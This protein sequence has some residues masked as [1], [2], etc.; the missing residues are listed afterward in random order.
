M[1]DA[2]VSILTALAGGA[3]AVGGWEAVRYM[4]NRK[5]NARKEEAEA[6]SAEFGVLRDTV[7]FLQQQLKEKEERFAEQTS[8]VR[9]QNEDIISLTKEKAAVELDLQR[10]RCIVKKCAHREPQN[11]Y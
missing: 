11:G 6:D 4:M 2:I 10:F 5:A 9:K 1:T 3:T 7:Q 8:L